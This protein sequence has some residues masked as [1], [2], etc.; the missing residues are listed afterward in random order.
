MASEHLA[1]PGVLPG[2]RRVSS[3]LG[4]LTQ[5]LQLGRQTLA[6]RPTLHHEA[7]VSGPPTGVSE[8]QEGERFAALLSTTS[9]GERGQL[10]ELD[11]P[12][13]VLVQL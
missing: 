7:P 11:P 1:Q 3:L 6:L 8:A 10:P 12:R 5:G 9:A 13:L 4:I 2:D